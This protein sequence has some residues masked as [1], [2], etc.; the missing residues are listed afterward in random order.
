MRKA[1]AQTWFGK[2]KPGFPGG[3]HSRLAYD[4]QPLKSRIFIIGN[5]GFDKETIE[6]SKNYT[7][8]QNQQ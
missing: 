7:G 5:I 6:M 2:S 4:M 1:A 3:M 8:F